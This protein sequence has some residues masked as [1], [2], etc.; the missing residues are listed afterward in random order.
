MSFALRRQKGGL[1]EH[2]GRKRRHERE[3]HQLAHARCS[4]MVRKPQAAEGGGRRAG[5]EENSSSQARLQKV[6]LSRP[7]RHDVVDFEGDP[8]AQE[9][10]QRDDVGEIQLQSDRHADFER[11]DD[12]DHER[13]ER[14]RDI[15][16]A[17]Q[18]DVKDH[19]DRHERPDGGLE[20]RPDNGRRGLDDEDRR[21]SGVRRDPVDRFD[22]AAQDGVVVCV[23]RR[24]DLDPDLTAGRN[25]VA[26]EQG[27]KRVDRHAL[28]GQ[29]IPHLAKRRH[30]AG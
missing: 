21:A 29:E 24:H 23:S 2:G 30:Q 19:R 5:A 12:G 6:R 22:E 9:Q 10:R 26:S 18:R 15:P 17:A 28:R 20:K 8:Y 1:K 3:R 13:H 27:R 4:G 14:Q 25:P 7:P 16:Q 11:D